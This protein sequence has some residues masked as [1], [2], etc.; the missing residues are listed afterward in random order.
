MKATHVLMA[1]LAAMLVPAAADAGNRQ[2]Q[3]VRVNIEALD[4]STPKGMGELERRVARAVN[5]IC[6][7]DRDCRDEA[8]AST[9]A[10]V[11]YAIRR[12][13]YM[14]RMAAERE[15]QLR[16]CGRRPCEPRQ[17]VRYAPPPPPVPIQGGTTVITI[18]H[19]AP[20]PPPVVIYAAPP[21]QYWR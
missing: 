5:R 19:N 8:W 1:A 3:S 18:V 21:Q 20:P 11:A 7:G 17:P 14:R 16:A 10:Q 15:A 9:E 6:A 2:W 13:V 4:L 12:D